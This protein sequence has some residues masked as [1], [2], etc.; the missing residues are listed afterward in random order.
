MNISKT[1]KASLLSAGVLSLM[2]LG[3]KPLNVHAVQR[4][5]DMNDV[6]Y[7]P[8]I[9]P[10]ADV[11][12]KTKHYTSHLKW[13]TGGATT[14]P[15]PYM[16]AKPASTNPS[17]IYT[18][19]GI[20][21]A[22]GKG[23]DVHIKFHSSGRNLRSVGFKPSSGNFSLNMY[24]KVPRAHHQMDVDLTFYEHGTNKQINWDDDEI[25]LAFSDLEPKY[26]TS[27]ETGWKPKKSFNQSVKSKTPISNWSPYKDVGNFTWIDKSDA[28]NGLFRMNTKNPI[29]NSNSA[30]KGYYSFPTNGY[31][32]AYGKTH[33][34]K[35]KD[36]GYNARKNRI[37]AGNANGASGVGMLHYIWDDASG[38]MD[39]NPDIKYSGA[40]G[41]YKV[42]SGHK[43][44]SLHFSGYSPGNDEFVLSGPNI[45][46]HIGNK[47]KI[48][49]SI[50]Y[51]GKISTTNTLKDIN[52]GM[53][54]NL[55]A[56]FMSKKG[57]T[58]TDN[59]PHRFTVKSVP[60]VKGFKFNSVANMNSTHKFK[61]TLTSSAYVKKAGKVTFHL[62]GNVGEWVAKHPNAKLTWP[63][64][65]K[66]IWHK[67]VGGTVPSNP[68]HTKYSKQS[69]KLNKTITY[70]GTTSTKNT[71]KKIS[72]SM[73]Y[74]LKAN[75]QS[76]KG[77]KITD[78]IP[79]RYHVTAVTGSKDFSH[80]SV[81]NINS[82][83]KFTATLLNNNYKNK[84]GTVTFHLTGNVASW[85][86]THDYKNASWPMEN[87]F[88]WHPTGNKPVTPSNHVFT[89]YK[90]NPKPVIPTVKS[91]I[92][93]IELNTVK[94][95]TG[96]I[97][98]AF[99]FHEG[100]KE[101]LDHFKNVSH[102]RSKYAYNYVWYDTY[103]EGRGKHKRTYTVRHE[104]TRY[105][106]NQR[107]RDIQN[108]KDRLERA[109]YKVVFTNKETGQTLATFNGNIIGSQ[110][111]YNNSVNDSKLVHLFGVKKDGSANQKLTE[112]L[113]GTFK[114]N[115]NQ[116]IEAKISYSDKDL[117]SKTGLGDTALTTIHTATQRNFDND[118]LKGDS[119]DNIGRTDANFSYN[120]EIRT[121]YDGST[122]KIQHF[123]EH[124]KMNFYT[125]VPVKTGY[126]TSY[127]SNYQYYADTDQGNQGS[128]TDA[129]IKRSFTH[130]ETTMT[131]GSHL[132]DGN[133][134]VANKQETIAM[135][136][137]SDTDALKLRENKTTS[138][139]LPDINK[140]N[141]FGNDS[142]KTPMKYRQVY[143]EI[144]SG[145][146]HYAY[147]LMHNLNGA[148]KVKDNLLDGGNKFYIPIWA[149]VK[150]YTA[151]YDSQEL[152]GSKKSAD[153]LGV[154][155]INYKFT[156][157]FDV[158]AQM[159]SDF[160]SKTKNQDELFTQP[161]YSTSDY[162]KLPKSASSAVDR[163]WFTSVTDKSVKG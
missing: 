64:N 67:P 159:Y 109:K 6:T 125:N 104:E 96:S 108:Y 136:K 150:G 92:D 130:P 18:N 37:T 4:D 19:I 44:I 97:P 135:Q 68:V 152:D 112:A 139:S 27:N 106:D 86:K 60:A 131:T 162:N 22:T 123:K 148:D 30:T 5:D 84:K 147:D 23:V 73:V 32:I 90:N 21:P 142:D 158:F 63:M 116:Q 160:K 94:A 11:N 126:Y 156:K 65:N 77:A 145:D 61:A 140:F 128:S 2:A 82:T 118:A 161:V 75:F 111:G 34:P 107:N 15:V 105:H 49:K 52:D 143:S 28:A 89:Y 33:K 1:V 151:S 91:N 70:K 88:Y 9:N 133:R 114:K 35:I 14:S 71:L 117:L 99:R 163:Q 155:Q 95:D 59:I 146:L 29:K 40:V 137:V 43:K 57:A 134:K 55:N 103:T 58:L 53:T 38:N 120:P 72:D 124:Y 3:S 127:S 12:G 20:D 31:M 24:G 51:K 76:G 8:V 79:S 78:S 56:D 85:A 157:K 83:H 98:L 80:N 41:L 153:N 17:A 122:G 66:A 87:V 141:Q 46:I 144:N 69:V 121:I 54:Y 16:Q 113:R 50:T 149:D 119:K 115:Y 101:T 74:N 81:A 36:P 48:S 93:W 110:N 13:L 102:P 100:L 47:V 25:A 132:L 10:Q 7:A 39:L 26:L 154:N 62:N 138:P 129:D 42:N 45:P